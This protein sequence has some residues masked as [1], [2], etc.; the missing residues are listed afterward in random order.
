MI[1]KYAKKRPKLR[2]NFNNNNN[3][4]LFMFNIIIINNNLLVLL[5]KFIS[6]HNLN[7]YIKLYIYA[8]LF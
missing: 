7:I 1:L 4:N 6:S 8:K 2:R 5:K 3:N